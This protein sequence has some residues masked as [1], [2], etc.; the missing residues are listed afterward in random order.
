MSPPECFDALVV[1]KALRQSP[2]AFSDCG[3]DCIVMSWP[4]IVDIDVRRVLK[5]EAPTGRIT[6]FTVQHTDRRTNRGTRW[7]LRRNA[8][9]VFNVLGVEN[10]NELP[11]CASDTPPVAPYVRPTEGRTLE[12]VRREGEQQ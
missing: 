1:G 8:S 11:R 9:G 6:V 7:W 2:T 3:D 12:D 5:G 10:E 4:W